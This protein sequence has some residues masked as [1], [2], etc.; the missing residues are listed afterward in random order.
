[1]R[2]KEKTVLV[3]G[4]TGYVGKRL[5][6]RLM[7]SEKYQVV[8]AGRNFNHEQLATLSTVYLDITKPIHLEINP[9]IIFHCAGVIDKDAQTLHQVNIDGTHNI[10]QF[11]LE[12]KALLVHLSSAGVV[13]KSKAR[14]IDEQTPCFP[15]NEYEK[16]K[17]AA[18]SV[19]LEYVAK[20]LQAQI[21]RPT[22]IF[23]PGRA[24]E[25]DS[26]L[27]LIRAIISGR[28]VNI[29][30]GIYNIVHVDDVVLA[31]ECVTDG[32]LKN[33]QTFI[34]NNPLQ[35]EKFAKIVC[36][37]ANCAK[38]ISSIPESF[39]YFLACVSGIVFFILS[40]PNPLTFSRVRALAEQRTFC[41]QKV[42]TETDFASGISLE[43]RVH[44]TL[45]Y[46]YKTG[47]LHK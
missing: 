19:V 44:E 13:G 31:M 27:H 40:R 21:I 8:C 33:C 20:G 34:L 1:M 17:L 22:I 42:M 16:S 4:A 5:V 3:T 26:F 23:G 7:Q 39:G 32:K 36:G 35:F 43:R 15:G 11:A 14:L 29:G 37:H 9:D 24:P 41:S 18:E 6:M 46:Y 28:Y 30:K 38:N 45:D 47:L 10:A 25:K 2:S 12:K